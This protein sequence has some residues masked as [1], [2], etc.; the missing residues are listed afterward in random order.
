MS[1]FGQD[2]NGTFKR[3]RD[4]RVLRITERI[5]NTQLTLSR[6]VKDFGWEHG[7]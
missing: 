5:Y 6:S 3:L 4:G 7:W 2:A 1:I